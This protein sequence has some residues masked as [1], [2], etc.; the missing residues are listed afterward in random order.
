MNCLLCQS[1][2][3]Q[4]FLT[5]NNCTIYTCG[6]CALKFVYPIPDTASVY[7]ED[8]FTG[9][10]EGF[11]YVDYDR[12][13]EPM[14]PAF[15]EYLVRVRK[16]LPRAVRLLD[17]GAATGFFVNYAQQQGFVASGVE[18]SAYAAEVGRAHGLDMVTGTIHALLPERA[19]TYDVITMLDVIEHVPDP[20]LDIRAAH[21]LLADKGLLMIN[22]PDT[23]SAYA[24]IMGTGWHLLTPPEH[25]IYFNRKNLAALLAREG[26]ETVWVGTIGKRFTLPYI[27]RTLYGWQGMKMWD[28]CARLTEKGILAKI[29]LPI[30]LGDN[31]FL[32]ARKHAQESAH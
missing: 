8:Y 15:H 17:V 10:E 32:I 26:F 12:D 30:N 20:T 19:G 7:G 6:G 4:T 24:N 31:L 27:F 18:L 25:L 14:I 16:L 22:T 29:A 5:K 28:W 23:G 3:V 13:K 2:D 1:H 9:A 21:T 11:G